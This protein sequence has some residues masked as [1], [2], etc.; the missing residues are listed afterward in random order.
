[1]TEVVLHFPYKHLHDAARN[2]SSTTQSNLAGNENVWDV[3]VLGEQR[4]VQQDSQRSSVGSEDNHLGYTSVQGL[5]GLVGTLLPAKL[6]RGHLQRLQR[7]GVFTIACSGK[8]AERGPKA[9]G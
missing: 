6:V 3:L 2:T 9:P 1:M 8:P 4:Q 7:L 5:R